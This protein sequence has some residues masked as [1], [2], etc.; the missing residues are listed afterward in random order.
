MSGED[1][2]KVIHGLKG[3]LPSCVQE[4]LLRADGEFMSWPSVEAAFYEGYDFIFANK[5]CEP[6]FDPARWYRSRPNDEAAFNSCFYQPIGW[7]QSCRFVV[8]RILRK[9]DEDEE[10][11]QLCDSKLKTFSGMK[12][13]TIRIAR[14]KL[15]MI[16]A[17]LVRSGN[18]DKVKYPIH[19]TRTQGLLKFCQFL[20][21]LRF[22]KL[23][24]C[25]T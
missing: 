24:E 19:D 20:V 13:H 7:Q 14:L 2:A 6:L 25:N 18:R 16:A 12:D 3:H 17:K 15:L 10:Q 22:K 23:Q 5:K 21:R 8:M 11:V 9:P 1:T 4:V